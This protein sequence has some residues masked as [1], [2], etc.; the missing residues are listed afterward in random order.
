MC[1]G[2]WWANTRVRN[3][4]VGAG[5]D[6]GPAVYFVIVKGFIKRHSPRNYGHMITQYTLDWPLIVKVRMIPNI[7]REV[8][9]VRASCLR[10][11]TG[12]RTGRRRRRMK[13]RAGAGEVTLSLQNFPQTFKLSSSSARQKNMT[14]KQRSILKIKFSDY[15]LSKFI[16]F[17]PQVAIL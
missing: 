4:Q 16:K 1:S 13:F 10:S 8:R 6:C 15:H 11:D 9:P 3:G 12:R 2:H 17:H 7:A 5:L 14:G